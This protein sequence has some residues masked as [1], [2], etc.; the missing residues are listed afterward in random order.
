[1][2]LSKIASFITGSALCAATGIPDTSDKT[3][4]VAAAEPIPDLAGVEE[5]EKILTPGLWI[6]NLGP[7]IYENVAKPAWLKEWS[8]SWV[9]QLTILTS[10]IIWLNSS[11]METLQ[12]L[13]CAGP[14]LSPW[15][16]IST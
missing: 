5:P 1:M 4:Q 6:V 7:E 14:T 11:I 13:P 12:K 9:L 10:S 2:K 16:E 15:L 3:N 8:R